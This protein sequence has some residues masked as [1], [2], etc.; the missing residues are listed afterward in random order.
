MTEHNGIT[1]L[2]LTLLNPTVT[3][4]DVKVLLSLVERTAQE[5]MAK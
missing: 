5:V 2:K 3:L 4:E 1:C